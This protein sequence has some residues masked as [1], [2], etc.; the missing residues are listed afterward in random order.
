MTNKVLIGMCL[1]WL[2]VVAIILPYFCVTKPSPYERKF[3]ITDETISRPYKG[4]EQISDV[5]VAGI[6]V[7]V[8]VIMGIIVILLTK[9]GGYECNQLL[10][11]ILTSI[12]ITLDITEFTKALFGRFR[13]DFLSR[14][15]INAEKVNEILST[16]Y[17]VD[18]LP[19]AQDRLFDISICSNPD[20]KILDEGRRSFPSGHS[21]NT[22]STFILLA[23]F[24]AGRLKVF[25]GRVYPWRLIV[26]ILPLFGAIYIMATRH[27]DNLHHWSDLLGG[28]IIGSIIAI[29]VYHFYFPPVY[30]KYSDKPYK[31]RVNKILNQSGQAIDDSESMAN[32][33]DKDISKLV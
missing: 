4:S 7:F 3:S 20:T 22:C 1:D 13:P 15:Q 14:C 32:P 21:S 2:T 12:G 25:D 5:L 29:I 6:A 9:G 10:L 26:S 24:L 8:P 33:Y 31:L 28:A 18:G 27:Q 11:A 30:S 23:L 16:T 19:L 17:L